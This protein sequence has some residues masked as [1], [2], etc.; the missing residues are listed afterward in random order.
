M[1]AIFN[2]SVSGNALVETQKL[3]EHIP[4]AADKA[5]TR[6]INRTLVGVRQLIVEGI[7]ETYT[8]HTAPTRGAI[9]IVNAKP[10]EN[11][12]R[13]VAAGPNIHA[14]LFKVSPGAGA[15]KKPPVGLRIQ[16]RKDGGGTLP[17]TFWAEMKS[18]HVGVFRRTDRLRR[19][20]RKQGVKPRK[21]V[22]K[23]RQVIAETPGLSVASMMNMVIDEQ[24]IEVKAIE[25]LERE[26]THQT[27][28]ILQGHV[29]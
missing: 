3:L 2:V 24:D 29:K 1:A 16:L 7:T 23:P 8:V 10:G 14:S 20:P 12:G 17:G 9:N 28:A 5:I 6:S 27:D 21:A 22:L 19:H 18:G 4:G 13:I 25:R 26:L 11:S 15:K